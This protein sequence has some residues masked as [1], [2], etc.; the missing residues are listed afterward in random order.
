MGMHACERVHVRTSVCLLH[1]CMCRH[2]ESKRNAVCTAFADLLSSA[3][4]EVP[5]IA[6]AHGLQY[7]SRF[8][9]ADAAHKRTS[10]LQALAA[11]VRGGESLRLLCHCAPKRC[12]AESIA[13]RITELAAPVSS[14][15][16]RTAVSSQSSE[17]RGGYISVVDISH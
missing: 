9:T 4:A 15:P 16:D 7:D 17:P 11:R 1:A 14:S 5:A 6:A 12:H 10:A 3:S 8:A 2:D 13:A